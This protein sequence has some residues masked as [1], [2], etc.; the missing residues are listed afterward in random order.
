M[1]VFAEQRKEVLTDDVAAQIGGNV[2]DFQTPVRRAV[3]GVG[4]NEVF[5]W[6]SVKL[7]PAPLLPG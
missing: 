5:Q 1:I 7:A 6:G 2:T 4:P 3:V